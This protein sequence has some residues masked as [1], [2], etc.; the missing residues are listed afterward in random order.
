MLGRVFD[1]WRESRQWRHDHLSI[2]STMGEIEG[3]GLTT[4]QNQCLN[5]VSTY[6][7][8]SSFER[9]TCKDNTVHLK[10]PIGNIGAQLFIYETE[11]G[12][13]GPSQD[14][15]FEQWDFRTPA[16]LIVA[17]TTTLKALLP[18]P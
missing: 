6:L 9:I 16:D 8:A 10:A 18:S 1:W 2:F 11:A 5:A 17:V 13:H 3:N 12:K 7:R 14:R 15:F 4:F